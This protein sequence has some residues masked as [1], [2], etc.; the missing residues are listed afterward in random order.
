MLAG[1]RACLKDCNKCIH[2]TKGIEVYKALSM[3]RILECSE[4]SSPFSRPFP[5]EVFLLIT[6]LQGRFKSQA[7]CKLTRKLNDEIIK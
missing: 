7:S 3:F 6:H 1:P 2:P 4:P 5:L